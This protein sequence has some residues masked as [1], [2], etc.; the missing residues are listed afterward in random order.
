L[1]F[2]SNGVVAI[3]LLTI[4]AVGAFAPAVRAENR[5]RDRWPHIT[6]SG[7]PYHAS[8]APRKSLPATA[9]PCP[10]RRD[11]PNAAGNFNSPSHLRTPR[12]IGDKVPAK[13]FG[14]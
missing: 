4:A 6:A 13:G 9:H 3:A 12:Q 14:R 5:L 10:G 8:C 11:A 1:P 2:R 7:L